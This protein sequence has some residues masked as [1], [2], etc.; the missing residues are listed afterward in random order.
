MDG[1]AKIWQRV[2]LGLVMIRE[3]HWVA[4]KEYQTIVSHAVE[5]SPTGEPGRELAVNYTLKPRDQV[6]GLLPAPSGSFVVYGRLTVG[7]AEVSRVLGYEYPGLTR[8]DDEWE[9]ERHRQETA[10][11]QIATRRRKA[12][13]SRVSLPSG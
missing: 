5:G 8:T 13:D 6:V 11:N 1:K 9:A 4:G 10:F 7:G 12:T 3:H 2:L